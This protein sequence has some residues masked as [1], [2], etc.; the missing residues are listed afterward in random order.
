MKNEESYRKKAVALKYEQD[1]EAPK[2]TAIGKGNVAENI[3]KKAME[4]NVPIQS[5]PSLVTLLSEL[6]INQT[7]PE[8]L[9]QVV[10]EVFAYIYQIDKK[11]K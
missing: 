9:Y 11:I 7:I 8:E 2:V 4:S 1:S 5:D 10:A 3:V 6:E